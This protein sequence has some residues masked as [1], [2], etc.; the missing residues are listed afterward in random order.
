MTFEEKCSNHNENI[1]AYVSILAMH[2]REECLII[3][4]IW[5]FLLRD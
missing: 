2:F 3:E 1:I 5:F 4:Y